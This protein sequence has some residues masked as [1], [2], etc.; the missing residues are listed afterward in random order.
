ML[1]DTHCHLDDTRYIDDIEEVLE[2]ARQNGVEKFII[3]G[4]DPETLERAVE[5]A[6]MYENIYFSVGVHPYDAEHYDKSHLEK[7]IGHAK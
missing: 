3:P 6:E 4:A 5:L 1:V 7:F 2:N